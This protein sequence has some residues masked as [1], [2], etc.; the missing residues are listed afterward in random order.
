MAISFLISSQDSLGQSYLLPLGSTINASL[1]DSPLVM[2]EHDIDL[3]LEVLDNTLHLRG[4]EGPG[5]Y[6]PATFSLKYVLFALRCFLT[7]TTNQR[8]IAKQVGNHMNTLLIKALAYHTLDP[9]MDMM[10]SESAEYAC[11]SLYVQSNY[12]FES[13]PFLPFSLKSS[14][15]D[16][17]EYVED[18][19]ARILSLY[20]SLPSTRVAGRHAA[21]QLL[22]RL[23]Y[24]K[25]EDQ[26]VG[27]FS[28][29]L[30]RIV[31]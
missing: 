30:L 3:L 7:H 10:D 12:G 31:L 21:T 26:L 9:T 19:S 15:S 22:L 4:K 14:L 1:M 27:A 23:R 6:S 17:I 24:L 25:F 29:Y 5:G 13:L 2:S 16:E 18:V 20:Q 8:S 11:F 28:K